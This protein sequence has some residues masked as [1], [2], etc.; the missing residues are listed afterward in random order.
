[1]KGPRARDCHKNPFQGTG[2]NKDAELEGRLIALNAAIE[3]ARAGEAGQ[4]FS[5]RVSS[6]LQGIGGLLSWARGGGD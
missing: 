6:Y 4:S 5:V 1:M 2:E 3:A